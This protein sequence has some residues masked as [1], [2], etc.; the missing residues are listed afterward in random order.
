MNGG[1]IGFCERTAQG[2]TWLAAAGNGRSTDEL[3]CG[4]LGGRRDRLPMAEGV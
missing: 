1:Y 4:L 2:A 3:A